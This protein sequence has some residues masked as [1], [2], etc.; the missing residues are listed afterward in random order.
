MPRG[1][2]Y[3]IKRYSDGWHVFDEWY[4][5]PRSRAYELAKTAQKIANN[6]NKHAR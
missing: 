4:Q 5:L 6:M 3:T 2:R 1:P